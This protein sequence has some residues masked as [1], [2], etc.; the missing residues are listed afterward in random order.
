MAREIRIL[1]LSRSDVAR[2]ERLCSQPDADLARD[3]I[4]CDYCVPFSEER[5]AYVQ[6]IS[7]DDPNK[8]PCWTQAV[9]FQQG[10]EDELF[11]LACTPPGEAILGEYC[12][13]LK[14]SEYTIDVVMDN[15]DE[16]F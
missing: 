15:E 13:Y 5:T 1:R 6:I 4:V 9:L 14:D 2:L 8:Q 3:S 7:S 12:M 11:E 16:G 10:I